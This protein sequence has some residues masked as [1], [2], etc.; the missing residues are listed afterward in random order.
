MKAKKNQ[1]KRGLVSALQEEFDRWE[2][3]LGALSDD[4]IVAHSLPAGLSIKDVVAHLWAW[5]QLSVARLDAALHNREPD[6]HLGPEGLDPDAEENLELI[7]A[8]IH[9]TNL[10]RSWLDVHRDWRKGSGGSWNWGTRSR[11]AA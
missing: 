5:Q 9:E 3:L 4:Q 7:N 8:W 10:N 6:F 2:K 1:G 11:R